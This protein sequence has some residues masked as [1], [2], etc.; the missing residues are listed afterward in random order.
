MYEKTRGSSEQYWKIIRRT[1][2]MALVR[3]LPCDWRDITLPPDLTRCRSMTL[4]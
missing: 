4:R 2:V 1:T 3:H